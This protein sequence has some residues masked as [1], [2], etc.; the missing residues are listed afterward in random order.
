MNDSSVSQVL[1]DQTGTHCTSNDRA[2]LMLTHHIP[3]DPAYFRVKVRRRL[4]RIG[5]VPL[6]NSVYVLP[7]GGDALEDFEWLRQEIER[8]GGQASICE[9]T[10]L[11]HTTDARLVKQFREAGEADYRDVVDSA[12][13]LMEQ[14]GSD[15]GDDRSLS[16]LRTKTSKIER[17]LEEVMSMDFFAAPGRAAAQGALLR[18]QDS[19]RSPAERSVGEG[20]TSGQEL[21]TG[22]TW[23]T[24]NGIKV[25]RIASAWLIR[26]FIDAA[27]RFK[28]VP[29][30]GYEP[31]EGE[32]RFD[33]FEGE[34]THV[35][36]ACTFETLLAEFGLDDP[37][38]VP[39][40]QII[41]DIDCKDDKFG[42]AE[43]MGVAS[44]IHGITRAH[45]E[46]EARLDRGVAMLD[47]LYEHFRTA[48]C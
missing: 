15:T 32:L 38:L 44:L 48:A 35:G 29:A 13:A 40:G 46:D 9:A 45:D 28:F 34:Y 39:L 41:H 42:R 16:S 26:R 4:S 2:W 22:G 36:E 14:L 23:V 5:A 21:P 19:E 3:P 12:R 20:T 37:A 8:E 30:R 10:F 18:L 27:A 43:V 47:D 1:L 25:D 6:K 17:R 11:D 7:H 24:R 33:M 31:E